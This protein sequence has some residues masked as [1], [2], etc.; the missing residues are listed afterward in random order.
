MSVTLGLLGIGFSVVAS[1]TRSVNTFTGKVSDDREKLF[2]YN[3]GWAAGG[4][5]VFATTTFFKKLLNSNII[6]TRRQIYTYWLIAIRDTLRFAEYAGKEVFSE[7]DREVN[8]SHCICSINFFKGGM[9]VIEVD[10][11]DFAYGRRK[12][13]TWNSLIVNPPRQTKRT[14]RLIAKYTDLA[15]SVA[16]VYEAIYVMACFLNEFSKIS[17]WVSNTLD[18]GISLQISDDEILFLKVSK[19]AK[20]IKKLYKQKQDL[21]EIMIVCG[22]IRS[23]GK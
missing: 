20:L 9:P 23:D 11:L 13:N 1:D 19:S 5:G 21:S 14:K 7:V 10:T 22:K 16:N 15:R 18:C 3:L 17:K 8:S 12:L 4:G 2:S 6:K